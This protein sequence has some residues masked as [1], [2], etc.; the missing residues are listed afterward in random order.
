VPDHVYKKVELTGSSTEGVDD[1][2][3]KAV[4]KAAETIHN[5]RWFEVQEIRGHIENG[6]VRHY[7]VTVKVGFTID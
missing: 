4:D 2:I 6:K 3:A 7:Q 1:A 5:L